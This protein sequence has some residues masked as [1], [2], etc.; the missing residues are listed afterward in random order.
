[1]TAT[2]NMSPFTVLGSYSTH[3][4]TTTDSGGAWSLGIPGG[5]GAGATVCVSAAVPGSSV[6]T[7]A[8]AGAGGGTGNGTAIADGTTV[9]V[10]GVAYTYSRSAQRLRFAAPA[11][12][13][14]TLS[15]G[16]VPGSTFGAAGNRQG[17][18]TT[19]V[20]HPHNFVAGTSGSLMLGIAV[21]SAN[22]SSANASWS[23]TIHADPG[24]S[25]KVQ[26]GAAQ[27]YP[28]GTTIP[29]VQGQ[30]VCVVVREVAPAGT[31]NGTINQ[32][33][34]W[35]TLGFSNASP[36]L[37]ASYT[38]VDTTTVGNSA[39]VLLK[40]VRNVTT[41]GAWGTSNQARSGQV[42]E[43]RVTYTNTTTSPMTKV[44][45]GDSAP[46]YTVFQSAAAGTVPGDLGACTMNTP[47]NP[48]P[49][50]AVDCATV[51]PV[52]GTGAIRWLFDGRLNPGASGDVGFRV[53]VE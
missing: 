33:T 5:V 1:M 36:T 23:G 34:V 15:F 7:G 21:E 45:I 38:L 30:T 3:A 18:A 46:A 6:A 42:L 52:G 39:L 10:G 27:L 43:Y 13:T 2:S 35:A 49:A 29:V 37:S 51:Q 9:A 25:G 31:D 22:A 26:S 16:Q 24:C 41:G 50:A 12:G 53:K 17:A 40:E 28:G 47:A 20:D 32:T 4:S 44:T 48:A 14:A 19:P 8:N 11:G